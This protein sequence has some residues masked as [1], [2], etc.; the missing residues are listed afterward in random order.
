MQV[1]YGRAFIAFF[2]G[3]MCVTQTFVQESN[4]FSNT[5]ILLSKPTKKSN[6]AYHFSLAASV[7]RQRHDKQTSDRNRK[8]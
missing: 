7:L 6:A 8:K 5:N 4:F 2:C 1:T 3:Q